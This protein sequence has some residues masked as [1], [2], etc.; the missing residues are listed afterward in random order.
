MRNG[1]RRIALL[2]TCFAAG[3]CAAAGELSRAG[4]TGVI[5][6]LPEPSTLLL[7]GVALLGVVV[8]A[9]LAQK[10]RQRRKD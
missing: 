4:A 5:R 6:L 9:R 8:V 1:A 2:P 10:R 3:P 7:I